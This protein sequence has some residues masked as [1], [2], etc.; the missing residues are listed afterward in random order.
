MGILKAGFSLTAVAIVE[1]VIAKFNPYQ[2]T[3]GSGKSEQL[4]SSYYF[5]LKGTV[6][7]IGKLFGTIDFAIIKADVNID[8]RI[9]ASFTFAPYECILF[10]E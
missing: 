3:D 1:G 10:R 4:E 8:I 9:L 6:G 5:W 7:I 2:I